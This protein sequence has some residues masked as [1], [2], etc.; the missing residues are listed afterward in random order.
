MGGIALPAAGTGGAAWA[1]QTIRAE[2]AALLLATVPVWMIIASRV[3]DGERITRRT[4]AGLVL[5]VAG[6][7][8]LV[9]PLAGGAPDLLA[10]AV[11]LGG[12]LFWGCGSVYAKRAPRPGR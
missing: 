9:N 8:V 12:A 6:V 4:A 5:G 2:T 10:S 11:A 7:V 3:A 1:E